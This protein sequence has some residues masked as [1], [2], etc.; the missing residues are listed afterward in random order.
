MGHVV[1]TLH[2]VLF[3]TNPV[4][5]EVTVLTRLQRWYP[6]PNDVF[7]LKPEEKQEKGEYIEGQKNGKT[8]YYGKRYNTTSDLRVNI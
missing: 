4:R 7:P 5:N 8:V 1:T 3:S 6:H 2:P